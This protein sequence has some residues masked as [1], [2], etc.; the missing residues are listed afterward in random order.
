MYKMLI[1]DDEEIEREGMAQL[2]PWMN[3]GVELVGTARNGVEGLERIETL[4][5]DIVLTDI[6]MPVMNGI[7]LIR[8]ARKIFPMVEF[9]VLSG[10]GEYEY[11][12][13]A[14]E[15]GVRHYILK[16]CD[17]KKIVLVL[18]KA[19]AEV[20]AKREEQNKAQAYHH[21]MNYLFPRAREQVLRNLLL[22]REQMQR[23]YQLFM[24]EIGNPRK[25]VRLLSLHSEQS[26]DYIEQ[27][28]LGNIL[29]ELLGEELLS[30][31]IQ[32][33]I[34]FLLGEVD[35][36]T[37]RKAVARAR[38]EFKRV[39]NSAVYAAVSEIGEFGMLH[40]LYL[41]IQELY[42]IGGGELTEEILHYKLFQEQQMQAGLTADF[43]KIQN[44]DDYGTI[45]FE[46]Y[47]SFMKMEAM[48]YT[49]AR[50]REAAGWIIKILYGQTMDI[51]ADAEKDEEEQLWD[52]IVAVVE[53]IAGQANKNAGI[54][55]EEE[56]SRQ[57]LLAV[58]RNLRKPELNIQFLAKDVLYMN[59]EY[60]G[61]IFMRNTKMKFSAFLLEERIHLAQRMM[62]YS[63]DLKI[64][65]L[66]QMVGYAPDGQYFSRAFRKVVGQT[67][68]EYRSFLAEKR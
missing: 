64:A 38:Q 13:Q 36:E 18:E 40:D 41:Q 60:F 45:L 53:H 10:Y 2:I 56:R 31:V 9:V 54:H 14:M 30:A 25:Q 32:K 3:Y 34:L 68:S 21:T 33:D 22:D 42:R 27:F 51:A 28:V 20:E 39:R 67:P 29:S 61:R 4:K 52:M 1:V 62:E 7:E 5:P 37:V 58:Y 44:A 59:E 49:L 23:D 8:K 57:I 65:Q 43:E 17:E 19:K 6:K 12:S 11:T 26:F 24:A 63:P 46:I 55:K 16:P 35:L 50:K 48:G 66:A 15:E 47:L